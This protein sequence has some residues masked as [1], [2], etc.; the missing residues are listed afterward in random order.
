MPYWRFKDPKVAAE[1]IASLQ[2]LFQQYRTQG[3][4]IGMGMTR[5]FMQMGYTR[6]RRYAK[7]ASGRKY[8]DAGKVLPFANDELN[9]QATALFY[10]ACR[11]QEADPGYAQQ[12]Q[13]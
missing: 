7:H 3:G 11:A 13:V 9:A 1:S 10:D 8:D 12:K 5:K 2:H 4:F 6:A